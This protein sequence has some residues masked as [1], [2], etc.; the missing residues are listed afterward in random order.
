MIA[1]V[2][3]HTDI[4]TQNIIDISSEDGELFTFPFL[5]CVLATGFVI[6]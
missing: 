6:L 2:H 3:M 1:L 5:K 4:H